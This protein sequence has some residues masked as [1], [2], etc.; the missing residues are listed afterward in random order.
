MKNRVSEKCFFGV[1]ASALLCSWTNMHTPLRCSSRLAKKAFRRN[2]NRVSLKRFFG[3]LCPVFFLGS[4]LSADQYHYNNMLVGE[5][6]IGMGGAYTAISDD[7]SG[8]YYNPGGLGFALSNDL[9]GSANA[10]Y[11]RKL[12]YKKT[13]GGDDFNETV[14]GSVPSFFG[15]LQKLDSV[16]KNLVF[17]FGIYSTD[18][19]SKDQNDLIEGAILSSPKGCLIKDS[20][21]NSTGVRGPARPNFTLDRLHR[22]VMQRASSLYMGGAL[23]YRWNDKV[24]FGL[25]VNYLTVDE[26]VQEYQDIKIK[27]SSCLSNGDYSEKSNLKN[28]N[29]RQHLMGGA[30]QTVLG[31]Q[32]IL[33]DKL[34][35]GVATKFG[36]FISQSF[37]QEG[38]VR[39][40]VL[41]PADQATV[42]QDPSSVFSFASAGVQQ[43][44]FKTEAKKPL[45]AWMPHESRVGAAYFASPSLLLSYDAI[46]AGKVVGEE[47]EGMGDIY[48]KNGVLN[49]A[50]GAEY[51]LTGALPLRMGVFTNYD[52]RPKVVVGQTGQQDHIDYYGGSFFFAWVQPNS[53]VG[54]GVV[55]QKGK[56]QAQK[57]GSPSTDIQDVDAT[58][59]TLAISATHSF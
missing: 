45:G 34:S 6:A 30:L 13:I 28:Q 31:G 59:V 47:I 37:T 50:V 33:G 22:T 18:S 15:G 8:L 58:S 36:R 29:I 25:G 21:G 10:F 39:T 43:S 24:S 49:H 54:A 16:L 26:L 44:D 3:L 42:D 9:S 12:T 51:Y 48:T 55:F 38:E 32:I 52:S 5:R 56:G 1:V 7:A 41:A 27:N 53:Q 23:G 17:A 19:E 35:L 40:T 11:S 14:K 4:S 46:Y 57:I 2:S 20:A